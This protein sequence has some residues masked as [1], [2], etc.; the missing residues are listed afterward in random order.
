M[1][2]NLINSTFHFLVLNYFHTEYWTLYEISFLTPAKGTMIISLRETE[3]LT[4]FIK[5]FQRWLRSKWGQFRVH[6]QIF[7]II[8]HENLRHFRWNQNCEEPKKLQ[9]NISLSQSHTWN[10]IW[11]VRVL[12]KIFGQI[13]GSPCI[14][15]DI[16]YRFI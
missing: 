3:N 10:F 7:L 9:K 2:F 11:K 4:N 15:V 6:F 1:S 16:S 8:Y 12:L 13:G 5:M 14:I